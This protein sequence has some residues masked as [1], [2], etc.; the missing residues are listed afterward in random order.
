MEPRRPET[1]DDEGTFAV[2]LEDPSKPPAKRQPWSNSVPQTEQEWQSVRVAHN[3]E[4]PRGILSKINNLKNWERS[5]DLKPWQKI[6]LLAATM[7]DISTGQKEED[8]T[9]KLDRVYNQPPAY[10]TRRK[11]RTA[12][13][14]LINLF[15]RLYA[16]LEH[17]AFE[18]LI[19]WDIPLPT[20]RKQAS[21]KYEHLY[22]QFAHI[23]VEARPEIQA[24]AP[25]YLPFLVRLLRPQ[26]NLKQI[27][28]ALKTDTLT[29]HDWDNFQETINTQALSPCLLL[30]LG[31][32]R[33]P[34]FDITVESNQTEAIDVLPEHGYT[35]FSISQEIQQ[36]ASGAHRQ[37]IV[38]N[39]IDRDM[40]HAVQY[41]WSNSL[42]APVADQITQD[43]IRAGIV[44][45]GLS[46]QAAYVK[47]TGQLEVNPSSYLENWSRTAAEARDRAVG[48]K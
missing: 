15:D 20:L 47:H 19:I 39:R 48:S 10:G 43:L 46:R 38:C 9:E 24:A 25:F 31:N 16:G 8:D 37:R 2:V 41:E 14:N 13:L 45:K 27:G 34:F 4:T 23:T 32:F 40:G 30:S 6:V 29:E 26:Y 42:H 28:K 35:T 36:K 11:D 7:V 1:H 3:L 21:E 18:L 22:N 5:Y 12:V 44:E 33:T 17:R